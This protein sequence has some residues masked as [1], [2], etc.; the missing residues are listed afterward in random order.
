MGAD[1]NTT[2]Q[3]NQK[4]LVTNQRGGYRLMNE[5]PPEDDDSPAPLSADYIKAFVKALMASSKKEVFPA[6]IE[7]VVCALGLDKQGHMTNKAKK[8]AFP[9]GICTLCDVHFWNFTEKEQA[10]ILCKL[11]FNSRLFAK[12]YSDKVTAKTTTSV[13][14]CVFQSVSLLKC[15]DLKA[16]SLN[17]TMSHEYF[18]IESESS[19]TESKKG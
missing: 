10:H 13:A 15:I 1:E 11:P 17:D 8:D 5:Y 19:M 6:D 14:S 7:N 18:Q 12:P 3:L 4:L 9:K 2:Y 16:G